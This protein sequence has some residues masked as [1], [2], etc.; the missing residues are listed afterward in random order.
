MRTCINILLI[1]LFSLRLSGQVSYNYPQYHN[2]MWE[3]YTAE[4]YDSASSVLNR[5]MEKYELFPRNLKVYINV[6]AKGNDKNAIHK[7]LVELARS[8]DISIEEYKELVSSL[9]NNN[10]TVHDSILNTFEKNKMIFYKRLDIDK[11]IDLKGVLTKDQ[12]LRK[13]LHKN[14]Q[15]CIESTKEFDEENMEELLKI[16]NNSIPNYREIGKLGFKAIYIVLMHY[17]SYDST[18]FSFVDSLLINNVRIGKIESWRYANIVDRFHYFNYNYQIYG[19][20]TEPNSDGSR[21]PKKIINI[22]ELD[23]RRYLLGLGDYDSFAKSFNIDK[24]PEGY[25]KKD[26]EYQSQ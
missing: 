10:F 26:F 14:F 7:L 19:T 5:M 3:F 25:K 8:T 20:F 13:N 15:K 23:D 6:A 1:L 24:L 16:T 2:F 17:S 11:I 12:Y 9:S 4:K 18:H 22:S 21:T